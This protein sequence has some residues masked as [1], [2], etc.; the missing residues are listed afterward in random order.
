MSGDGRTRQQKK[1]WLQNQKQKHKE[2]I[3]EHGKQTHDWTKYKRLDT[4]G[5]DTQVKTKL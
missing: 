1:S 2:F 5:R 4:R 3:K